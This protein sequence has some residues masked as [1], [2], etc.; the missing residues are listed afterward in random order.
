MRKENSGAVGQREMW[1]NQHSQRGAEFK[2]LAGQPNPFAEVCCR[3][4][5]QGVTV[6]E[7]GAAN[8]RDSACFAQKGARVLAMDISIQALRQLKEDQIHS[9]DNII[10]IQASAPEIPFNGNLS[11]DAFYA[12]AAKQQNTTGLPVVE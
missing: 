6:L 5:T 11:I 7:L 12:A 4:L 10:P 9:L 2:H 8:G 1:E 3:Y